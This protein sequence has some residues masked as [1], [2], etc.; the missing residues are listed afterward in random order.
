MF[1]LPL[2]SVS[3]R[4]RRVLACLLLVAAATLAWADSGAD[5]N[6]AGADAGGSGMSKTSE[7]APDTLIFQNGDRLSGRFL[8]LVGGTIYF[9]SAYLGDIDVKSAE[10]KEVRTA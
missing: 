1:F 10:V 8:R 9:H 5:R 2:G 6:A 3:G 4:L 7:S